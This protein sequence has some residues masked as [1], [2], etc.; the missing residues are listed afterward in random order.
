MRDLSRLVF[1]TNI[2]ISG[3]LLPDS[4]PARA[5]KKGIHA[6]RISV[7]GETL[8]ELADVLSRTKF[9]R[10]ISVEDRKEYFRYFS[11]VVEKIE[12]IRKITVCRDPKD[13]KFLE[14]AV[15]GQAEIIITGDKDLLILH[16]YQSIQI[17]TP[18]QYLK[19]L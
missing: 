6:G 19:K 5:V 12:I 3:L 8:S 18:A 4:Q 13:N 1:D 2:L 10:Y 11:R 9:N 17:I 7:S 14:V 16:P 15:N